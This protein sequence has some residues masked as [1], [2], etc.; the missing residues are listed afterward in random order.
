MKVETF[1]GRLLK[2]RV[3]KILGGELEKSKFIPT[4]LG[5]PWLERWARSF[6]LVALAKVLA[7]VPSTQM[8]RY[9]LD[10]LETACLYGCVLSGVHGG[11]K[12][13][14]DPLK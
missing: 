4:P 10:F 2:S 6:A 7:L 5:G 1:E 12:R 14:F 9:L 11:K 8:I 13:V 3:H